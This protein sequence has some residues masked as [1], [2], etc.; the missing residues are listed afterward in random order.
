MPRLSVE[1]M[2][3]LSHWPNLNVLFMPTA[4]A[5]ASASPLPCGESCAVSNLLEALR[6]IMRYSAD[7]CRRKIQL[8]FE[9]PGLQL[10][11]LEGKNG[12]QFTL[13]LTVMISMDKEGDSTIL[14][15]TAKVFLCRDDVTL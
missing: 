14:F 13:E 8:I 15:A 7:V 9:Y 3:E 11:N 12:E 5:C 2:N 1:W 4:T 6:T 10:A